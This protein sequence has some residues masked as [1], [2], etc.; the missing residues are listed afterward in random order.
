MAGSKVTGKVAP[1]SRS[2]LERRHP[3]QGVADLAANRRVGG[4]AADPVA[5]LV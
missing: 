5:G 2:T 3:A 4:R 1:A